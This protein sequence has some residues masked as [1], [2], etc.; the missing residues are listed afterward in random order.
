MSHPVPLISL[1]SIASP[2]PCFQITRSGRGGAGNYNEPMSPDKKEQ[3][4]Q[5]FQQE[6]MLIK[7]RQSQAV[8]I[9]GQ[10]RY[11]HSLDRMHRIH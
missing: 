2:Y 7:E 6:S 10:V 4:A 8:P 5:A 11:S 9:G 1:H 3:E